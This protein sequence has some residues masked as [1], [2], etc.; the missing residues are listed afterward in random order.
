MRQGM[1]HRAASL[2]LA[3]SSGLVCAAAADLTPIQSGL[4]YHSFANVEQFR[5]THVELDLR[6]D[7][8]NKVL[9]GSVTLDVKRLDP[10]ATELVL[11]TRD[12]D[13]RDVEERPT[14]VLGA[15]SKS[16]TT[17]V[18]RPFHF[19]KADTNLGS[20]LVIEVPPSKKS[21][22]KI[23]ISYV[24]SP[25]AA[26]LQWLSDKQT[27]GKHHPYMYTSSEPIGARSWIPLQDTP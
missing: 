24:T 26:A 4:D 22:E 27:A 20:P 8:Y 11:D 3:C 14:N 25:N 18:T 9:F 19:E 7:F 10:A 21:V 13:V 1:L 15:T 2:W 16:E 23:R 17:W 5:V 6:V 12:L